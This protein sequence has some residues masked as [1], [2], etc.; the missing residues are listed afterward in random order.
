[1]ASPV[2]KK[3]RRDVARQPLRMRQRESQE[4]QTQKHATTEVGGNQGLRKPKWTR[5]S[6]EKNRNSRDFDTI[7]SG[8]SRRFASFREVFARLLA[9]APGATHRAD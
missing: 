8:I 2:T 5:K 4:Q 7:L 1:M 6:N 9:R 3:G